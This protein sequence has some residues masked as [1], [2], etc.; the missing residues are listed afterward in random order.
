VRHLYIEDSHLQ[1]DP[2]VVENSRTHVLE[3]KKKTALLILEKLSKYEQRFHNAH[4]YS[5]HVVEI[6]GV[7]HNRMIYDRFDD[8]ITQKYGVVVKNWPLKVFCN[9]SSVGSRIELETLYNGWQSGITR[10]E[11]LTEA[12]MMK[13]DNDRFASRLAASSVAAPG[14]TSPPPPPPMPLAQSMHSPPPSTPLTQPTHSNPDPPQLQTAGAGATHNSITGRTQHPPQ[15]TPDL[16]LISNM[17]LSDPSLQN[18]D[19]ILLAASIQR[20]RQTS[21][22]TAATTGPLPPVNLHTPASRSKRNREA[23]QVITPQSYGAPTKRPRKGKHLDAG[24]SA[25]GSE[26]IPPGA[27][28]RS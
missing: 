28:T 27:T 5:P 18:I 17:I 21:A 8:H 23:F 4:L 25:K 16:E 9:P 22:M 10:F 12:E 2:G 26:N 15:S 14:L 24:P 13:W 6:T 1:V 7:V 3:L 19:P 11:K 20:E